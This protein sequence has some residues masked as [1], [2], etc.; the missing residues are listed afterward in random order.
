MPI[1]VK[2]RKILWSRSGNRCAVCKKQLV[3]R[4][5]A[6]NSDLII[7]EE[8]HIISSKEIGPRG[9]VKKLADYDIYENLIL[10]CAN[11]HKLIDEFPETFT[12]NV[13]NNIKTNH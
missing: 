2:T 10:L 4:V 6:V 9:N 3:Q 1:K 12:V 13:I 11:D 8:C 5:S 7:G